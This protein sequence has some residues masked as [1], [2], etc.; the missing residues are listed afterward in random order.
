MTGNVIVIMTSVPQL[1]GPFSTMGE[2]VK[3]DF[4]E[5]YPITASKAFSEKLEVAVK[6]HIGM[7]LW[8]V[9]AKPRGWNAVYKRNRQ[10]E[11]DKHRP[12]VQMYHHY[13]QEVGDSIVD[14][15]LGSGTK[16]NSALYRFLSE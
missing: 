3:P 4:P 8:H 15:V 16:F 2:I 12:R 14:V 6:Q 10:G 7:K 11:C 13:Q 9:R 1:A 5:S